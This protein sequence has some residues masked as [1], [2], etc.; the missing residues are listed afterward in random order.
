MTAQVYEKIRYQGQRLRLATCPDFPLDHPRI[1]TLS[2]HEFWEGD[3]DDTIG[4]TACWREYIGSW[5]IRR[6]KLY[7]TKLEGRFWIEGQEAIFAEWFTGQLCI[8]RGRLLNYVHSGFNSVYEEEINLAI[9]RGVVRETGV[10]APMTSAI[11][12]FSERD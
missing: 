10:T 6:G 12:L 4:S 8:P 2:D 11:K 3:H 1:K 5:S 9:E 7:L